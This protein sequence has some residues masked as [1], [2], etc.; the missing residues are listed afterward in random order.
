MSGWLT[1]ELPQPHLYASVLLLIADCA[2]AVFLPALLLRRAVPVRML[3]PGGLVF[4]FVMLVVRPVGA[5]YLPRTLAASYERYGTI[6]L[7]FA[8]IGWLYVLAFCL[9]FTTVLGQVIA[10]DEGVAGRLA[11]GEWPPARDERAPAGNEG[12]PPAAEEQ[13]A[14]RDAG[15]RRYRPGLR[16]PRR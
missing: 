4:A 11:R 3:L 16:V 12:A 10:R 14:A 8:Y 1:A 9:L 15:R 13:A 5:V 7:A 6:G 2:V